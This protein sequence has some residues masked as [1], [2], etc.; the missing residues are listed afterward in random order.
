MGTGLLTSTGFDP[1]RLAD[2]IS[3]KTAKFKLLFGENVDLSADSELGKLL[4]EEADREALLWERLE[5]I[6]DSQQPSKATGVSLDGIMEITGASRDAAT[7]STVTLYLRGN[8][9]TVPIHSEVETSDTSVK[10]RTK[11]AAVLPVEVVLTDVAEGAGKDLTQTGGVAT[12]TY[13][14]HGRS[15][16]QFLWVLGA[17]QSGY[18]G[19][20]E[21]LT[22]GAGSFT[23]A[24]DAGT[25]SPATGT[26]TMYVVTPVGAESVNT[27]PISALAGTLTQIV[28]PLSGWDAVTNALDAALGRNEEPDASARESRIAALQGLGNATLDAIRGDILLVPNV[29]SCTVFEN[30]TDATVG[31]RPPHSIEVVVQGGLDQDI[32]NALYTSKAGGMK[33]YGTTPGTVVDSQGFS[34]TMAFSRPGE[35]LIY[36]IVT[37]TVDPSLYP[38]DG[39]ARVLAEI[40]TYVATL[41]IGDDVVVFPYLVG[42]FIEIPGITGV[43]ID[44]GT[45]PAPTL[46]ANIVVGETQIA[47]FDSTRITVASS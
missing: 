46:D 13:P 28:N 32:L 39:D 26:V 3:E 40:L 34:H 45:A 17:N 36:L 9:V 29:T 24:V 5:E 6:Y 33:P 10:F 35:L 7:R 11:L 4:A 12:A 8:N 27:G 19:I 37:L 1:K 41:S 2:I 44:I 22:A 25:V 31:A 43:T 42:S 20:H 14:S 38:A 23:Y 21:I 15:V 16:G 30:D 47:V 18:D